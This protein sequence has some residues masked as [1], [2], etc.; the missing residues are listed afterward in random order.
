MTGQ[1][2]DKARVI[3]VGRNPAGGGVARTAFAGIVIDGFIGG[4][5]GGA[6]RLASVI[7]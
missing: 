5:T 4:V 1:T 6:G 2:E 3:E 7:E